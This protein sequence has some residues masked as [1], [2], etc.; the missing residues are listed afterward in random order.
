MGR[1]DTQGTAAFDAFLS[2]SRRD[3]HEAE[4]LRSAIERFA[5]PWY[6]PRTARVFLDTAVMSAGGPLRATIERSPASASALI[7]LASTAA[8]GS[9]WV[10]EEVTW[11]IDHRGTS[12]LFIAC[13]DGE[14]LDRSGGTVAPVLPSVLAD[15]LGEE[16]AWVDLRWMR[17][18]RD[19]DPSDPRLTDAAAQFVAALRGVPKD[20]VV[21]EHLR[22]RTQTRRVLA[23]TISA[24]ATLLIAAAVMAV[25]ARQPARQRGQRTV[26][27]PV[28]PARRAEPE[29]GG[30]TAQPCT[31]APSAGLSVQPDGAGPR[32][33]HP[34]TAAAPGDRARGRTVRHGHEPHR[35][36]HR[37][38][39]GW[40]AGGAVVVDRSVLGRRRRAARATGRWAG[41]LAGRRD[42]GRDGRWCAGPVRRGG[43]T[44]R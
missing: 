30:G 5:R 21:G 34:F 32:R 25:V 4:R 31:A 3:A 42:P 10:I 19:L 41:L 15:A 16:H 8:R 29:P 12:R 18:S 7:V 6:R 40:P 23:G 24:L 43:R 35:A 37:L 9:T 14:P 26:R 44:T 1:V 33:T 11:W 39:G 36:D 20:D 2:Y 17:D 13:L 28:P 22:R 27:R 38:G